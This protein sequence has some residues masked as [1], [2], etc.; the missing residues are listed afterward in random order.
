MYSHFIL[1]CCHCI[2]QHSDELVRFVN[3]EFE[4]SMRRPLPNQGTIPMPGNS[5]ENNDKTS[6][7]TASILAKIQNTHTTQI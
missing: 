4:R 1:L 6:V 3:H 7:Q 5:E 2:K